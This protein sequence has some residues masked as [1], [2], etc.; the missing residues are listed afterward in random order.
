MPENWG[1]RIVLLLGLGIIIFMSSNLNWSR[2]N[3][4]NSVITSDAKGYVAYLP[5]VFIFQDPNFGFFD[6]MEGEKYYVERFYYDYRREAYGKSINKYFIGVS[7]LSTPFFLAGHAWTWLTGGDLDGYSKAYVV[8]LHLGSI[9]Y[10]ALGILFLMKLLQLYEVKAWNRVL[11]VLVLT[12]ATNISYYISEEPLMS[13]LFNFC[14]IS[15]FL[16]AL[17]MYFLDKK[18]NFLLWAAFF[19]GM[20]TILRPVNLLILGFLPFLAGS[21]GAFT[22]FLKGIEMKVWGM[23]IGIFF[24]VC[25][26]QFGMYYWQTGHFWVYSYPGEG[27]DLTK[28]HLWQSM[29]SYKKGL[30][31]YTP[32]LFFAYFL[33]MKFLWQGRKYELLSWNLFFL[34]LAYI[35]SS[36]SNWY[37]GGSFSYRPFIDYYACFGI[38]LGMGL[39]GIREKWS[40]VVLYS[41]L[42]VFLAVNQI[43]IYQYRYAQIPYEGM[44]KESYWENFLRIDKILEKK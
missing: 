43:Q 19:L 27:L 35:L 42:F 2:K 24:L 22:S 32:V 44:T 7:V 41:A 5:A 21:W 26:L 39:G 14:F 38:V 17:K 4:W 34:G 31:V 28:P 29:F 3:S 9:F 36:W 6:E 12:F 10:L 15:L 8:F 20:V 13:H 33:G 25:S 30:F 16:Y 37:Y 1:Q 11:A 23:G 18:N 40:R